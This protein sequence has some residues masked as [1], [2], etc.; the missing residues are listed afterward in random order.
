[1]TKKAWIVIA[2]ASVA[3]L[4]TLLT[5]K[6]RPQ[7][8]EGEKVRIGVAL[9]MTGPLAPYA[10]G[11]RRGME[12]A[13]QE[14]G[15]PLE[16]VFE[17]AQADPKSGLS[18]FLKLRDVHGLKVMTGGIGSS[19]VMAVAPLANESKTVFFSCGATSPD[20]TNAGDYIFRNRL[21]GSYEISELATLAIKDLGL[22]TAAI[23]FVT[24]DYGTGN[25]DVISK[26]YTAS[27]GQIVLS[28]GFAS[29]ATDF[30]AL[31]TKVKG[32]NPQTIFLV[33]HL[34]ESALILKQARE[35]GLSSKFLSAGAIDSPNLWKITGD[36]A[37]GVIYSIQAYD[38]ER[39]DAARRFH[40]AYTGRFGQP[41]D[42]FAALGYDAVNLL[43]QTMRDHGQDGPAVQKALADLKS[44]DGVLGSI[45]FDTNGDIQSP[46][47][48]KVAQDGKFVPY[49]R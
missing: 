4:A 31:L 41:P 40:V 49:Q 30:R 37:N 6:Y 39:N 16:L 29:G 17:D 10:Q 47:Q 9:E 8:N 38:P 25:R 28:E 27:G 11:S 3:I 15:T 22:R 13:A 34:N 19:T 5:F 21:S 33:G 26:V 1:M 36:A 42:L 12:L 14:I 48:L 2:V 20:I 43:F 46:V 35:L 44:Y 32:L 24:T 7:Y 18:A 23:L 45:S